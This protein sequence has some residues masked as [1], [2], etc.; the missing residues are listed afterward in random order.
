MEEKVMELLK[1]IDEEILEFEGENLF[2]AGLLDSFLVIELVSE[3]EDAFDIEIDA[4]YVLEEN[5]RTKENIIK[6]M[7]KLTE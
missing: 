5:F 7:K 6:L 1:E 2:E 4:K 3:L